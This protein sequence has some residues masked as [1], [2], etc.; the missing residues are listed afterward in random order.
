[1]RRDKQYASLSRIVRQE[2]SSLSY[3]RR[4]QIA[5]AACVNRVAPPMAQI[6]G[7]A[8][9]ATPLLVMLLIPVN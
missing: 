4:V 9:D 5:S 1:M 2:P 6:P 7:H 3:Q 8:L